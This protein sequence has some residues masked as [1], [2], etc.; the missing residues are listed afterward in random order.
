MR[1]SYSVLSCADDQPVPASIRA[2]TES[3]LAQTER[4]SWQTSWLSDFI[5]QDALEKYALTIA[6]TDE[7]VGLGAYRNMPESM[8]VFVEYIESSPVCNPTLTGKRKYTGIGASLLAFAIQLSV[9]YGYGGTIC[10]KAKTTAIR[11]HYIKAFGAIPFSRYD[12]YLLLIDG[13]AAK[14]LFSHFLKEE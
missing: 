1:L 6:A 3:D 14:E 2:A 4:E 8:L 7:L 12:P 9:D 11:E 5:R 10:L 13:N